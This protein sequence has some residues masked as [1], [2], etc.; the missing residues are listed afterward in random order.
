MSNSWLVIRIVQVIA[1]GKIK[2]LTGAEN[3]G[4]PLS[5]NIFKTNRDVSVSLSEIIIGG[6]NPRWWSKT[7]GGN[8]DDLMFIINIF[9]IHCGDIS[10]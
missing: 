2:N 4:Y 5:L 9:T 7:G 10:F 6:R 3:G 8:N 1:N